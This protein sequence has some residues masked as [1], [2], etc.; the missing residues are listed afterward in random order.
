MRQNSYLKFLTS[1][2][3]ISAQ[4][5]DHE[6]Q[7]LKAIFV[8]GTD[9]PFQVR[10]ILEMKTI[11]SQATLH[12]ALSD[13]VKGGYLTLKSSNDDGRVKYVV[14]TQKIIKLL[15]DLDLKLTKSVD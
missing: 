4:F 10:D 14:M 15:K 11:A 9:N 6:K 13:L 1:T 8:R 5:S 12:K 2:A 3:K 7:V